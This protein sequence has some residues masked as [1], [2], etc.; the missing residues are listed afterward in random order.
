MEP[1]VILRDPSP[2]GEN[3]LLAELPPEPPRPAPTVRAGDEAVQHRPLL[4]DLG[5]TASAR[6]GTN[7]LLVCIPSAGGQG[8]S[9]A[10]L[11]RNLDAHDVPVRVFGVEL[12]GRTRADP[13]PPMPLDQMVRQLADEVAERAADAPVLVLGHCAGAPA[14]LHLT[15]ALEARS[16]PVDRII[17]LA[18][19][20]RSTDPAD[21]TADDVAHLSQA[22]VLDRLVARTGFAEIARLGEQARADLVEA[23]RYDTAQATHAL[24][25]ALSQVAAHRVAA[26]ATVVLARDDILLDDYPAAV[27]N[28]DLFVPQRR[29]VVADHGGHHLHLTRTG[30]LAEVIERDL[31]ALR[32]AP[33]GW[34]AFSPAGPRSGSLPV[35]RRWL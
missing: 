14:A 30:L 17:I 3:G 21:H 22:D 2:T 6:R 18:N 25:R 28:W 33:D 7:P 16:V 4:V 34:P 31:A 27:G 13:R 32:P 15:R 8:V 5:G 19:L 9:Y 24:R 29:L 1:T 11:S 20:L 35:R 23:F 26:P 12:P 10:P